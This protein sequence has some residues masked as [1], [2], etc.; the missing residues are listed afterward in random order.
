M[1][2]GTLPVRWRA[3]HLLRSTSGPAG[4][5]GPATRSFRS[6]HRAPRTAHRAPLL[7]GLLV[8]LVFASA[9]LL[10][11]QLGQGSSGLAAIDPLSTIEFPMTRAT[12]NVRAYPDP[13]GEVVAVLSAG[14]RPEVLGRTADGAWLLVAFDPV[15]GEPGDASG[16]LPADR[17]DLPPARLE[18]LEVLAPPEPPSR[19]AASE[20]PQSLPDLTLGSVYL[21]K[22]GRIALDIRNDGEGSLQDAKI[23]LLVTRASGETV[24]VL[25]V[26]P[27][28][29]AA[30]G[31]ATVI[32]PIVV[33]STG[34]YTLELD[35]QESIV[36]A[37]RSN[38]SVT[39][40]LVVGGG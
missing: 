26:G 27:T 18:T 22:D 31:V 36:E 15:E 16:W 34:T 40:L 6:F 12:T 1:T 7:A 11:A 13:R 21:L 8:L 24:G 37:A 5:R 23:P 20:A 9:G 28:T 25:E 33:T 2:L 35:R 32:T 39:R 30:R 17:L 10:P 38:N 3:R 14:R 29:L 4:S 19:A